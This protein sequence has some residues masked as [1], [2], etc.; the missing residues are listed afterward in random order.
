MKQKATR[1]VSNELWC[2][3][4]IIEYISVVDHEVA[5]VTIK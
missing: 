4:R 5:N 1:S 3:Y 2:I